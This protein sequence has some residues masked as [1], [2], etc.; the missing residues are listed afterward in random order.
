MRTSQHPAAAALFLDYLI[1]EAQPI[2]AQLDYL[3]RNTKEPSDI[4]KYKLMLVDPEESLD[5][6]DK[7]RKLYEDIILK[8]ART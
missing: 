2:Y 6:R 7:W 3:P 5:R 1:S 8:G 4:R